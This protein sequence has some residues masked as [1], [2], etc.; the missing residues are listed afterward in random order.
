MLPWQLSESRRCDSNAHK[1]ARLVEEIKQTAVV[2]RGQ[3]NYMLGAIGCD[4]RGIY[5]VRA[6]FKIILQTEIND[7]AAR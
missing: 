3:V 6:G 4:K 5:E 2:L 7:K 1:L